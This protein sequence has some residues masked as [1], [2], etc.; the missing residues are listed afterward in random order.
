MLKDDFAL[1]AL[2]QAPRRVPNWTTQLD[3]GLAAARARA[4]EEF[5]LHA[6]AARRRAPP[7]AALAP[8]QTIDPTAPQAVDKR[9]MTGVDVFI[10]AAVGVG[11]CFAAYNFAVIQRTKVNPG[12]T[13]Q[14]ANS[15]LIAVQ[16]E[17]A[18]VVSNHEIKEKMGRVEV[19]GLHVNKIKLW[20]TRLGF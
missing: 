17:L 10:F 18:K 6:D 5:R 7:P 11:I 8:T 9:R 12:R 13:Y 2:L 19:N 1:R 3:I 15:P 14:P 4:Q 16:A 20:L